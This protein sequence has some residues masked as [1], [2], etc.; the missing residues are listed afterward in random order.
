MTPALRDSSSSDRF[1]ILC[2]DDDP[3]VLESLT[4]DLESVC[5]GAME[6]ETCSTAEEALEVARALEKEGADIPL[7]IVDHVLPGMSGAD[8]LL[9]LHDLPRFRPTRKIFLSGRDSFQDLNRSLTRGAVNAI[10]IKPWTPDALRDAVCLLLTEYFLQNAPGQVDRLANL[11]DVSQLSTAFVAAQRNLAELGDQMR[12]LPLGFRTNL[13]MSD[14]EIETAMIEGFDR[15]LG[16]PERK[17]Y[18]AGSILLEEDQPVDGIMIRLEGEI[19]LTRRTEKGEVTLLSESAGRII[20]LLALSQRQRAFYT[21]RSV[22]DVTVIPLSMEQLDRA[23]QAY[24]ALGVHFL[25]MV[26]RSLANRNRHITELQLEVEGLY[27]TLEGER[28]QLADALQQLKQAQMRLIQSERM[29]TLGQLASGIAHELNNPIAAIKRAADFVRDDVL[30]F[31]NDLPDSDSIKTVLHSAL[32]SRPM[33]T[34]ELREARNDLARALGDESLAQRLV[35]VG[36]LSYDEYE[37]RFARLPRRE[38]HRLLGVLE[39][40]HKLGAALRNIR[41]CAERMTALVKSLRSYARTDQG[42]AQDVD[43]HEGL[44]DTLLLF[45]HDLDGVTIERNYADLPRIECHPGE[46]NQVWTNLVGNALHAMDHKGTLRIETDSPERGYVRVRICDNGPGIPKE[47]LEKVF[48]LH[49][50]TKH[51]RVEFGLGMGLAICRQIVGNHG[52]T[53]SIDSQPG[54]TCVTVILPVEYRGGAAEPLR[55]QPHETP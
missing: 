9:A 26:I 50:T 42:P 11:V 24:P 1:V 43:V 47:H 48:D 34:R 35:S 29:A 28:D 31:V 44:E 4:R 36:V 22:T 33:S 10:L 23:I 20:G 8:L 51:G 13:D 5:G 38:C 54:N 16:H 17:H 7:A 30:S 14:E 45:G 27:A 3:A 2:V 40:Y 6:L 25:T 52:G 18:A 32:E 41:S 39:R 37:L 49:F 15:A 19:E 53:I 21:C 12:A 55:E 46:I